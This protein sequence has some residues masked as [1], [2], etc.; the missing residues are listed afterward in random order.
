MPVENDLS[1]PDIGPPFDF[2]VGNGR[3]YNDRGQLFVRY[4][5]GTEDQLIIVP[6]GGDLDAYAA[7]SFR[8]FLIDALNHSFF[9]LV[10]S[11]EEIEFIDSTGL[12]V[13]VGA[14][15]RVRAHDGSLDIVST[16]ER[17]LKIFRITGLTKVFGVFDTVNEALL[18][19][20][21]ELSLEQI[22]HQIHERDWIGRPRGR[23]HP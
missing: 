17:L 5:P 18:S 2:P 15:K 19:R 20:G 13:L 22:D 21:G 8:N 3:I 11:L 12:M 10:I 16:E 6:Y 9:S 4:Q 23:R 1:V 14:L 7:P